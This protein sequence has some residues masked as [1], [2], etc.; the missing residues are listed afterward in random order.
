[1]TD[2]LT[3]VTPT[4]D[5]PVAFAL[6]ERWMA[7]QTRQPDEWIVADGGQTPVV[8]TGGQRH[9]HQRSGLGVVNFLANVR[10]GVEAA[11][12]DLIAIVE[13]DDWY[14]ARHLEVVIGQLTPGVLAA[15][16]DTQ[17]YYHLPHRAWKRFPNI[18]ACLCQT[19]FR[20]EALPVFLHAL[21]EAEDVR[22]YGIDGRFWSR[23]PRQQTSLVRTETVLG[24]KGLPGREGL[25]IGHRP[26]LHDWTNDP[27]MRQLTAWIGPADAAIYHGLPA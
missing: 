3:V 21:S 16:D 15:G 25:G 26:R 1:M 14:D 27:Q 9:L 18:G 17:R 24:I 22:H 6:C 11:T 10:R 13:D 19:V 12:G 8:C 7:R 2:R 4:A 5:R 23:L 20:R